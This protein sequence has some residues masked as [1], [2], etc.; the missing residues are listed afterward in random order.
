MRLAAR[1]PVITAPPVVEG[2]EDAITAIP[3]AVSAS[4]ALGYRV[5]ASTPQGLIALNGSW[6]PRV[7]LVGPALQVERALAK[8]LFHT[9]FILTPS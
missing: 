2:L 7:E 9:M 3:V 5:E 1:A 8:L 6:A 4:A